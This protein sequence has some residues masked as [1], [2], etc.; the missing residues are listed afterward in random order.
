[1]L[2]IASLL[3]P[4]ADQQT[5]SM[6]QML[7]DKCGLFGIMAAPYPHFSWFASEDIVWSPAR[8]KLARIARKIKPFK[9]RT[10]GLGIFSGPVPVLYVAL[11]KSPEL[12]EIHRAMW[13]RMEKHLVKPLDYYSPEE[14]MPHITIAHGDL[15]PA[16]ISCAV[17]DFAFES[18]KFEVAINN[19]SVIYHSD[20]GVGIKSRFELEQ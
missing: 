1:M 20:K 10:A 18:V 7:E 16:K 15:D 11:V 3:D 13:K 6:W 12:L 8:R 5:R 2:A 19:I 14:W 4:E 17:E 9:V